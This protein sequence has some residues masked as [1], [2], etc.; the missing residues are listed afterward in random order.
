LVFILNGQV[1]STSTSSSAS[2]TLNT[3]TL[4]NGSYNLVVLAGGTDG[5]VGESVY[6]LTVAN[7]PPPPPS[8][9]T[10][11]IKINADPSAAASYEPVPSSDTLFGP[12]GPSYL[13]VDQGE[14][15]DCWLIASLAEVAAQDP[16]AIK[17][18]FTYDGTSVVN[19]ATVGVYTV[20]FYNSKGTAE[21]VTIDTELPDGGGLYDHP[22]NGVLW[23]ALAEK[24]Y[25]VANGLGYVMT[26]DPGS[27]SYDALNAAYPVWALQAITGASASS[28]TIN[29][30]Q[31]ASAW[32]AGKFVILSTVSPA[33]SEI[34][35]DHDYAVVGYNA[36]TGMFELL[37]PWGGSTTSDLCPQDTQV[38]GLFSANASFLLANFTTQST[39]PAAAPP[40]TLQV[41]SS[42]A[43]LQGHQE[44]PL[45]GTPTYHSIQSQVLAAASKLAQARHHGVASDDDFDIS[46]SSGVFV[47]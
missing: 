38:F 19:G 27:N 43:N 16:Q 31:A 32:T 13:D 14:E 41:T 23:V 18:M 40:S 3:T 24:A 8:T 4:A 15:G 21:S 46:T 44:K 37:N 9:G 1:V 33:S 5:T 34:V 22:V 47:G 20:R 11:Q 36:S 45:N 28:I 35:G 10:T 39:A 42:S 2:W 29:P 30:T 12:N 6:T 7:S 17:N 25:A 26:S